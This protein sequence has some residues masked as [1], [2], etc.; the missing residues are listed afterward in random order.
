MSSILS[1]SPLSSAMV[2]MF[3]YGYTKDPI[4]RCTGTQESESVM[5]KAKIVQGLTFYFE[6]IDYYINIKALSHDDELVAKSV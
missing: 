6:K 1:C 5:F 4:I 2:V 3:L